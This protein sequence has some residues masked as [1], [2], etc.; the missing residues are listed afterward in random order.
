MNNVK[1]PRTDIG[2]SVFLIVVCSAVLW[3]SR[4]LPPGTFEPLG[5]APIP[6]IVA[7]L[8]ILL[9]LVVIAQAGLTLRRGRAAPPAADD[10]LVPRPVDAAA[11]FLLTVAYVLA[12]AL[13]LIGFAVGTALFLFVSIGLLVRFRP[14]LLVVA[15]LIAVLMGFGCQY[16]FTH[17]FFVDLPAT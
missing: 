10:M 3:E 8:I 1:T 17:I 5:S 15:A 2:L 16:V 13:G 6:R 4:R 9:S 14:R 7:G 12:M 11:I